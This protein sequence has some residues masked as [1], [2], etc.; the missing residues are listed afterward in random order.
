MNPRA[1]TVVQAREF[2]RMC[3]ASQNISM[4]DKI[5]LLLAMI[6]VAGGIYYVSKTGLD[7][8]NGLSWEE[9]FLTIQH[10]VDQCNNGTSSHTY[11]FT[12]GKGDMVIVGPGKWQEEVLIYNHPSLKIIAPFGPWETQIRAG[13]GAVKYPFTPV[14]ASL[15]PGACFMVASRGVEISGFC[16]D[17]GGGYAGVYIGDGYRVNVL[18]NENSA[19]ARLNNCITTSG[20]TWGVIL[21]GCSDNVIIED[22]QIES[23]ANGGIY[24][25][26]GGNRTV[27]YPII[28]RNEFLN[29]TGYG[30][31]LYSDA[32]TVGVT[33][34]ENLFMDGATPMTKSCLFQGAG[35][36][37]FAGNWDLSLNG[38]L[39]STTDFMAGNFGPTAMNGA[40]KHVS[41]S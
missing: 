4:G 40:Q 21:D 2:N 15:Q 20:T 8:N 6:G 28:R 23:S 41:E 17:G 29:M 7:T 19:S 35:K 24:I 1:L 26:P 39:G 32:T 25:C 9:S 11:G 13:D 30:I 12:G 37:I 16:L 5:R 34:K 18:Y 3:P 10:A 38:S 27:Q 31:Q 36:H 33:V 14:G 22:N